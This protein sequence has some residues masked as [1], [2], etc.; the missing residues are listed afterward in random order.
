MALSSS[1]AIKWPPKPNQRKLCELPEKSDTCT[2]LKC[3]VASQPPEHSRV[4]R[5]LV[6][7]VL[8]ARALVARALVARVLVARSTGW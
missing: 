2:D 3:A 5:V 6:A 7:K 4:A 1:K 8:V